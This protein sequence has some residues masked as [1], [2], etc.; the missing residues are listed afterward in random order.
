MVSDYDLLIRNIR[1]TTSAEPIDIGIREGLIVALDKHIT[2]NGLKEINGKGRLVLPGFVD[3]HMHLDKAFMG[4]EGRW[5]CST[6]EDAY[7]LSEKLGKKN[8]IFDRAQKT[9]KLAISKGT[10]AIR[11]HVNVN[12]L[13]GLSDI[14]TIVALREKVKSW[15]DIEIIAFHTGDFA[16]PPDGG[17]QLISQ[18]LNLGADLIGGV[19]HS[20][21]NQNDYFDLLFRL[22]KKFKKQLDLHIDENNDPNELQVERF[23]EKAIEHNWEGQIIG[24]HVCSLYWTSDDVAQRVIQK[25]AKANMTVITNPLTNLYI[26]GNSNER[27]PTG[28][29]RVRELLDAGI[30]VGVGTDNTCDMFAPFGNADM[31][32]AALLLGYQ[33]RFGDRPILQTLIELVT[34]K[35]ANIMGLTPDYGVRQN[36]KA[37]L[38]ILDASSLE[39]AF[40]KLPTRDYVIK[41]GH[42]IVHHGRVLPLDET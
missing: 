38:A 34:D 17:E 42:I 19:V 13:T 1:R 8:D 30:T 7:K 4:G 40:I 22:A 2:G 23:A 28:I 6:L 41:N 10:T 9:V 12:L 26:R 27:L 5:Q 32:L 15:V 11:T 35:A 24:S 18:A 33:R 20:T 36:C 25:I 21:N 14:E 16:C 31:L 3:L 39:E 37:D 29:T